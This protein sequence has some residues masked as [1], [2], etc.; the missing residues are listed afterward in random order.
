MQYKITKY[1]VKYNIKHLISNFFKRTNPTL[2]L[3][4]ILSE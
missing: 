3:Q 1:Q 4:R 2:F